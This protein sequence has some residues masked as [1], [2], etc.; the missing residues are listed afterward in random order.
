MA[1]PLCLK[2]STN[3]DRADA[4]GLKPSPSHL[5]EK[6]KSNH[7]RSTQSQS[8]RSAFLNFPKPISTQDAL[9][10]KTPIQHL[11]TR[12]RA[13]SGAGESI[14]G[15]VHHWRHPTA[16]WCPKRLPN[17]R[18]GFPALRRGPPPPG[19][20]KNAGASPSATARCKKPRQP[21]NPRR[22]QRHHS[23][24]GDNARPEDYF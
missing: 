15:Q 11:R 23:S 16:K 24:K 13:Y 7:L 19:G 18:D 20:T 10:P 21:K 9:S 14:Y 4:Q 22:E 3:R 17:N 5:V 12:K 2:K 1:T 8:Q 6:V